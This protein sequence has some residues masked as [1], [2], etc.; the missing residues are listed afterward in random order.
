M[1]VAGCSCLS[2]RSVGSEKIASTRET[3]RHEP[4]VRRADPGP[5]PDEDR[6]RL[7]AWPDSRSGELDTR[8]SGDSSVGA[9]WMDL[10]ERERSVDAFTGPGPRP[11]WTAVPERSL[12]S[13]L[14]LR[15]S[16]TGTRRTFRTVLDRWGPGTRYPTAPRR[17]AR[18]RTVFGSSSLRTR[19]PARRT[20]LYSSS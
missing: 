18:R 16:G 9:I 20:D 5:S 15:A 4:P 12:S 7:E 19:F 6:G 1:C 3:C 10:V 11:R 13:W 8:G 2:C 17:E 14:P